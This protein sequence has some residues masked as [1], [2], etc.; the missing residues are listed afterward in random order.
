MRL[1]KVNEGGYAGFEERVHAAAGGF[2][3]KTARV[4]AREKAIWFHPV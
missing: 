1:R 2:R 3:I 4:F